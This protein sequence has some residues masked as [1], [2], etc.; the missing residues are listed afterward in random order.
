MENRKYTLISAAALVTVLFLWII[1]S[2]LSWFNPTFIPTVKDVIDAFLD[3]LK[4]GYKGYSLWYHIGCSMKRLFI[5]ILMAFVGAVVLGM[6]CGQSKVILAIVNP[7]I[8][9]YRALPPLAY[10]TLIVL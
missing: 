6:I 7:F 3:I 4:N 5:A 2:E 8:Q 10:N 9:F 1:G